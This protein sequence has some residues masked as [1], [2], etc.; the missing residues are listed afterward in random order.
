[1]G[2]C[3]TLAAMGAGGASRNRVTKR[4]GERVP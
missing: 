1:M 3:L 2:A 4:G